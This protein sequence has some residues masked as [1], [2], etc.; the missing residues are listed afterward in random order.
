MKVIYTKQKKIY[1]TLPKDLSYNGVK[2][3]EKISLLK[4][5]NDIIP[6]CGTWEGTNGV[7][8]IKQVKKANGAWESWK[9]K[10]ENTFT[11]KCRITDPGKIKITGTPKFV[12]YTSYSEQSEDL[13]L[14]EIE[15]PVS[16]SI[17]AG[18]KAPTK[19]V[20]KYAA[21]KVKDGTKGYVTITYSSGKLSLSFTLN[22]YNY[23]K[24]YYHKYTSNITYKKAK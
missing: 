6:L 2:V 23:S 21:L 5:Y 17:K 14:K 20:D 13:E 22:D 10:Y 19:I 15:V 1:D 3:S 8:D 18:S 12:S 9:N 4:K 16:L 11:L 7:Y 24:E